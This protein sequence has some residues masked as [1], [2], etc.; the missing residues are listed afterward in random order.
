MHLPS[1][2]NSNSEFWSFLCVIILMFVVF[3]KW[4]VWEMREGRFC[5]CHSDTKLLFVWGK[6]YLHKH[7]DGRTLLLCLLIFV[8]KLNMSPVKI[9]CDE[10]KSCWIWAEISCVRL[11]VMF[12]YLSGYN[13]SWHNKNIWIKFKLKTFPQTLQTTIKIL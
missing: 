8:S 11:G 5:R 6:F 12:A 7:S 10:V 13:H 2:L 9:L 1:K 4:N 3:I